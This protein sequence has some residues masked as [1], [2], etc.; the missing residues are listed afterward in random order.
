MAETVTIVLP[1]AL[2][3]TL[4]AALAPDVPTPPVQPPVPPEPAKVVTVTLE[5]NADPY[6]AIDDPGPWPLVRL[7]VDGK[8]VGQPT[9]IDINAQT[10]RWKS[11]VWTLDRAPADNA[12]IAIEFINDAAH[13]TDWAK[14]GQDRNLH[15]RRLTLSIPG[16]EPL[17]LVPSAAVYRGADGSVVRSAGATMFRNGRMI[18]RDSAPVVEPQPTTPGPISQPVGDFAREILALDRP[19]RPFDRSTPIF[20]VPAW[21]EIIVVAPH[22]DDGS[23]GT[24]DQRPMRTIGAALRRRAE[25]GPGTCIYVRF[26]TYA[27]TF[28]DSS[29]GRDDAWF[30]L[31]GHPE[32]A[33]RP[34]LRAWKTWQAAHFRGTHQVIA[35]LELAGT[36]VGETMPDG[37]KPTTQEEFD[38]WAARQGRCT[39]DGITCGTGL[40]IEGTAEQPVHHILVEDLVCHRWA[41]GGIQTSLGD[42]LVIRRNNSQLN[43][44]NSYY[45]HSGI[46]LFY[47]K[48]VP[49]DR[50]PHRVIVAENVC[51]WNHEKV[52]STAIGQNYPT[53]GNGIIIDLT[54]QHRYPHATLI[55]GN[56]V[57]GNGGSGMHAF[58]SERVTFRNNLAIWNK[59]NKHQRD[60]GYPEIGV[61]NKAGCEAYGNIVVPLE[62]NGITGQGNVRDNVQLSRQEAEAAFERFDLD[63]ARADFRLKPGASCRGKGPAIINTSS[64]PISSPPPPPVVVQ[65]EPPKVEPA[66]SGDWIESKGNRLSWR[67][68][69]LRLVGPCLDALLRVGDRSIADQRRAAERAIDHMA[70]EWA[71]NVVRIH[72]YPAKWRALVAR[73]DG[74]AYL[75][76]MRVKARARGMWWML[77]NHVVG[78]PNGRVSEWQDPQDGRVDWALELATELGRR[79]GDDRS[80]AGF[81]GWDE[82]CYL[83]A[84]QFAWHEMAPVH[85]RI[86]DAFRGAGG[87]AHYVL[88][89]THWSRVY[90]GWRDARVVD[91]LNRLA[92]VF[93]DFEAASRPGGEWQNFDQFL[94]GI[95]ETLPLFLVGL[96]VEPVNA[97]APDADYAAWLDRALALGPSVNPWGD[98]WVDPKLY[99]QGWPNDAPTEWN[100]MG[101]WLRDKVRTPGLPRLT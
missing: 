2:A 78:A 10:A 69:D 95:H 32:D 75:D 9:A 57:I 87:R 6:S 39:S 30:G 89:G 82:P 51:A 48:E 94:D 68:A 27:E 47:M 74:W 43:A 21:R 31:I 73:G 1:R 44:F 64:G 49:G 34:I 88:T 60:R 55:D 13:P 37:F 84:G 79:Y 58:E 71:A 22:G 42:W 59:R 45:G 14:P 41:G 33:R 16:R 26:G 83:P 86:L 7:L 91:P 76:A 4:R 19:R 98:A 72:L 29:R 61:G 3:D 24:S 96:S 66:P 100:P 20:Q 36:R 90:K 63:L 35:G 23:R 77:D 99:A 18:W 81:V 53:D 28:S 80:F 70:D 92:C 62:G 40:Y 25:I 101:R 54:T 8:P 93:H 97:P 12:P 15:I 46:S 50:V 65:P 56:I 67:G 11:V 38:A 17:Q 85:Q 5:A 52:N